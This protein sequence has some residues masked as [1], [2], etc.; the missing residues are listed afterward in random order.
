MSFD[1]V[2]RPVTEFMLYVLKN[3]I[4]KFRIQPLVYKL[5]IN[6]SKHNGYWMYYAV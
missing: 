3:V 5:L 6:H 4:K 2:G 1:E